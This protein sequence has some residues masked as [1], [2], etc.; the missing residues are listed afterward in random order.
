VVRTAQL[1]RE[2]SEKHTTGEQ[3]FTPEM[4]ARLWARYQN[5]FQL[6]WSAMDRLFRTGGTSTVMN[7]SRA[8][9]YYRD[10]SMARTHI[11]QQ[12]ETSAEDNARAHFGLPSL[13]T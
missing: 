1:H 4:D 7:G 3:E 2:F 8:E 5:A 11:G 10:F 12:I 9:R 13:H 6:S